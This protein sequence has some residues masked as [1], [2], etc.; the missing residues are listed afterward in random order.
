MVSG[1]LQQPRWIGD[2]VPPAV[3]QDAAG[4]N[5][6]PTVRLFRTQISVQVEEF[7]VAVS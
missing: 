3:R 4:W 1:A 7:T 2:T 5:S 6:R